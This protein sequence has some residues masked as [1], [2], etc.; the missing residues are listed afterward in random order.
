MNLT[1]KEAAQRARVSSN[2]VYSWCSAGLLPHLRLGSPGRRGKILIEESD[3][4]AFLAAHKRGNID[5]VSTDFAKK[6]LGPEIASSAP[7]VAKRK[8]EFKHLKIK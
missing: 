1:P 6:K 2:L 5:G 3:L 4:E 7:N 8:P